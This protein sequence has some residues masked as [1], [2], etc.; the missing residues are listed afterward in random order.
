MWREG[1]VGIFF[2]G[3]LIKWIDLGHHPFDYPN[4]LSSINI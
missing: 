1:G 3:F 2:F 4:N